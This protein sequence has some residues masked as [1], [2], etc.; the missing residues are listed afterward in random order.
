MNG[1][2]GATA[3]REGIYYT[4]RQPYLSIYKIDFPGQLLGEAKL[5]T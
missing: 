5:H 2:L 3:E 1:G 4:E